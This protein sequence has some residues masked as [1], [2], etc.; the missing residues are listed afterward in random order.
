MPV[1][2]EKNY[3]LQKK[4]KQQKDQKKK[5]N[6]A[7]EKLYKLIFFHKTMSFVKIDIN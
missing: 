3:F 2:N 4:Q 5:K 6:N 7:P 1:K